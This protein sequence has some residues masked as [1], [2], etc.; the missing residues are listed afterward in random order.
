MGGPMNQNIIFTN[1]SMYPDLEKPV[2]ASK[3]IP[4]WYA[5]LN[6]YMGD[7]KVPFD[8]GNSPATIKRCMP[9]FDLMCSGYLIKS[10]VDVFVSQK[11]GGPFY[12]WPSLNALTFHP[13]EQAPNHP[14]SNGNVY[15]KWTN[16]WSIKTPKGYS[17]L[18][19][20]PF[21]RESV[22][23]ILP[24]LVDTDTYFATV[25]F[26]FVLNDVNFEGL[27]P[28]GTP[29]AQVIPVKRENWTMEF[30]DQKNMS[31]AMTIE[32][33]VKTGFFDRYKTMFR[34]SKQYK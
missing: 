13:I 33:S 17:T 15:P 14:D 5:D 29:I 11:D 20:P 8:D 34:Q 28:R 21:H 19:V 16:Y 3:E 1:V 23:K 6:S 7:K 26:P 18:F 9:V 2:P 31:E 22:F 24:A 4:S 27:I 32:Q 10:S 30:G 12:Q 25:N